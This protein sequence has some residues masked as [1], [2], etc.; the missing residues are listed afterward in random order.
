[1]FHKLVREHTEM[2]SLWQLLLEKGKIVSSVGSI[3]LTRDPETEERALV[4]RNKDWGLLYVIKSRTMHL[5]RLC[6]SSYPTEYFFNFAGKDQVN[7]STLN[8]SFKGVEGFEMGM[9]DLYKT[10]YN[11]LEKYKEESNKDSKIK[12]WWSSKKNRITFYM[13]FAYTISMILVGIFGHH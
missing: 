9:R 8:A 12:L 6:E 3:T 11:I 4:V 5:T 1:M 10:I 7:L 2:K 13:L